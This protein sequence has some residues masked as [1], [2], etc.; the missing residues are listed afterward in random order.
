MMINRLGLTAQGLKAYHLGQESPPPDVEHKA[1]KDM[2]CSQD[3][4]FC[5][6]GQVKE[7]LDQLLTSARGE[8]RGNDELE[9]KYQAASKGFIKR[10]FFTAPLYFCGLENN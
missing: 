5:E 8:N 6:M 3:W 2:K 7:I 10:W 1:A 4:R 9:V